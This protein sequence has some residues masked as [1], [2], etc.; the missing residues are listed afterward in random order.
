M[1]N[2][3]FDWAE[4]A[5]QSNK[6]TPPK[7]QAVYDFIATTDL[8]KIWRTLFLVLWRLNL[9]V[10]EDIEQTILAV[11]DDNDAKTIRAHRALAAKALQRA[12]TLMDQDL[13][14]PSPKRRW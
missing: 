4:L 11:D 5:R 7:E 1:K 14:G 2:K 9:I 3:N 10:V 6:A 12:I 8:A 13:E